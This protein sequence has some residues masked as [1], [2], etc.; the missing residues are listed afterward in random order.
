MICAHIKFARP[1]LDRLFLLSPQVRKIPCH[2]SPAIN[3][4]VGASFSQMM[5]KLFNNSAGHRKLGQQYHGAPVDNNFG[6][7]INIL[8]C[9]AFSLGCCDFISASGGSLRGRGCSRHNLGVCSAPDDLLCFEISV[10]PQGMGPTQ[11]Y[12]FCPS[13]QNTR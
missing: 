2:P 1:E 6:L 3:K 11:N 4:H 10:N 9:R 7:I 13:T 12:D 8:V 5:C